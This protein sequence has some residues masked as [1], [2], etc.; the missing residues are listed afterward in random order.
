MENFKIT[1]MTPLLKSEICCWDRFSGKNNSNYQKIQDYIC[2]RGLKFYFQQHE[3][4]SKNFKETY[5]YVLK[6]E[7]KILGFNC[8]KIDKIKENEVLLVQSIAIHPYEQKKRYAKK[9]LLEILTNP[10]T[11]MKT[12]PNI[13]QAEIEPSNKASEKLFRSL[14][15]EY[16]II[17]DAYFNE[18]NIDYESIIEKQK[19]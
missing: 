2:V 11:Y 4:N 9:L 3:E 12:I 1:E 7:S 14:G 15:N 17:G 6:D 13:V 19:G 10:D 8:F 5:N 16:S 18:I